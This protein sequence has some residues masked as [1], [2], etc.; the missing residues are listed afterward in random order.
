MILSNHSADTFE[1]FVHN[2]VDRARRH[3]VGNVNRVAL[4]RSYAALVTFLSGL[5]SIRTS[6]HSTAINTLGIGLEVVGVVDTK[7]ILTHHGD[8]G[9]SDASRTVLFVDVALN[10]AAT[11]N[12]RGHAIRRSAFALFVHGS[13][14]IG[15][16]TH[17]VSQ[18]TISIG[19]VA[20]IVHLGVADE[21]IVAVHIVHAV[22]TVNNGIPVQDDGLVIKHGLVN[23]GQVLRNIQVRGE[24]KDWA[25]HTFLAT[26]IVEL[27]SPEIGLIVPQVADSEVISHV[28]GEAAVL[29]IHNR[30]WMAGLRMVGATED[31]TPTIGIGRNVPAEGHASRFNSVSVVFRNRVES[32]VLNRRARHVFGIDCH[33]EVLGG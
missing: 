23:N 13:H 16:T 32:K 17:I 18:R 25:A 11:R 12:S 7:L 10:I 29:R 2:I 27:H 24:A 30:L 6:I 20:N 4:D 22:A 33:L 28:S 31:E 21:F 15:I 19:R 26:A 1:V 14:I 5:T 3:V 8:G 9:T